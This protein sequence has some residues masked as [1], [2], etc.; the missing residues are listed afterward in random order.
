MGKDSA[1]VVA[2]VIALQ[3]SR[4]RLTERPLPP[5]CHGMQRTTRPART[6]ASLAIASRWMHQGASSSGAVVPIH[7]SA[8]LPLL[9]ER[10][11]HA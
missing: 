7:G 8:L 4:V 3:R 10:L 11:C 2:Q 1:A 5:S 6:N 9:G